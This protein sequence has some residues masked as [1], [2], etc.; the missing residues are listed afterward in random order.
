MPTIKLV[1][2]VRK[3]ADVLGKIFK[4]YWLNTHGPLVRGFCQGAQCPE[5][6]QGR[7]ISE[8]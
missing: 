5:N 3:L 7:T 1:Y 2:V 8:D 4:E 6:D